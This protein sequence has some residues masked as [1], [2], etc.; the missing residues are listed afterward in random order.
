MR[1]KIVARLTLVGALAT[2]ACDGIAQAMTAHTDVL[3]RAAGHEL[4]VDKAAAMILA[5][6]QIPAQPDVAIAVA[7]LWVDYMLLAAAAQ[8]DSTLRNLKLDV[9]LQPI[10]DQEAIVQLRDQV[11]KVDT[12]FT[13]EELKKLFQ[14]GGAGDSIRA[15]HVLLRLPPDATPAQRD[16]TM[17]LAQQIRDRAR[18][19]DDFAA[20]ARQYS[21][22]GSAAQGG[23]LDWYSKGSQTPWV[24]PFE[25][26]AF[27]LQKGEVSDV[28]ETPFGFH[29]IKMDDRKTGDF[30]PYK[31]EFR[32]RTIQESTRKAEETYLKSLTDSLKLEV[33][34]GAYEVVRDVATKVN[35]ELK[36]RA[37]SRALVK[38]QG[39]EFTARDYLDFIRTHMN[40]QTRAQIPQRSDEELKNFL[41]SLARQKVLISEAS[42]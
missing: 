12:I 11:I 5:N 37:A 7:N 15:R 41:E 1:A 6:P 2:T 17:K 26:A 34:E 25:D 3:A 33:Q 27:K 32:A 9:V 18:A 4:K 22:D 40:Q 38:Y 16:S 19:G 28:V 13:D 39:D 31:D 14:E 29:V 20:M 8:Q 30:A 36:G 42:R 10:M 23:D 24:T 21:A 35:S